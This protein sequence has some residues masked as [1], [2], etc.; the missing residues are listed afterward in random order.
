ME[1]ECFSRFECHLI[2]LFERKNKQTNKT[3]RFTTIMISA[4]SVSRCVSL[5]Y[6]EIHELEKKVTKPNGQS[7]QKK[8]DGWHL[9]SAASTRRDR[10]KFRPVGIF[11]CAAK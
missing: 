4:I 10:P 1:N 5:V 6:I 9:T 8:N 7:K 11:R 3:N 2:F